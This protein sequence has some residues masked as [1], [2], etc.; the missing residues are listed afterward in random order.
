[1]SNRRQSTFEVAQMG[2]VWIASISLFGISAIGATEADAIQGVLEALKTH[3]VGAS[4]PASLEACE[5][6]Q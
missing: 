3:T 1:M 2:K 5:S 6:C 4:S